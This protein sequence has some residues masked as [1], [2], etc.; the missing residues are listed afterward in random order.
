MD[1][2]DDNENNLSINSSEIELL[3]EED[4]INPH[5]FVFAESIAKYKRTKRLILLKLKLKYINF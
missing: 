3:E 4:E 5:G 2:D 1:G